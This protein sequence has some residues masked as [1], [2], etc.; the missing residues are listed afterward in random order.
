MAL[1]T[2]NKVRLM[3][4]LST[5]DI[6]DGTLDNLICEATKEI[7]YSIN[8]KVI[9]EKIKYIDETRENDIDGSNTTYYIKNWKGTFI[10]DNNLDGDIDTD[11]IVVHAVD[12]N[13]T[14]TTATVSSIDYDDGKFVL[15]TAYDSS[16]DLY[17]S[18]SYCYYN[19]YTPDPLLSLAAT[20]LTASYA[21][22][23]RDV[24]MSG[25]QKFGNVTINSKLSDSYGQYYQRY[26][27][28][29]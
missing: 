25:S 20:Y 12:S 21:Y 28:K 3:T 27:P 10:G 24:G 18:Y 14:E 7:M 23:K 8:I 17:V 6:S 11:D 5:T 2:T 29:R 16:Y 9:R 19:P 26:L 22:L 4:N 13:G 15:S 1:T